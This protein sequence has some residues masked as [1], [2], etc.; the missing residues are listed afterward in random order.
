MIKFSFGVDDCD[1]ALWMVGTVV[2]LRRE[3]ERTASANAAGEPCTVPR[4][5][6]ASAQGAARAKYVRACRRS[7]R[8]GDLRWRHAQTVE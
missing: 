3:V 2:T 7:I 6:V 5:S 4:L 8:H 1:H